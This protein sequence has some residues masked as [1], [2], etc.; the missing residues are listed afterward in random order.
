M[1]LY[2]ALTSSYHCIK[3]KDVRTTVTLDK[4]VHEAALHLARASGRRLGKVLSDLARRGLAAPAA[5]VRHRKGRFAVFE[6]PAN[7]PVIPASRVQEAIDE[8]GLF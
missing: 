6:V 7:A 5:P 2:D 1:R 8:E 4:D 3:L